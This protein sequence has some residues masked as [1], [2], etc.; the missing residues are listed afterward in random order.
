IGYGVIATPSLVNPIAKTSFGSDKFVKDIADKKVA[1]IN[2]DKNQ[3]NLKNT[4]AKK[5][6]IKDLKT[7]IEE[8]NE[9]DRIDFTGMNLKSYA[10]PEGT[11][12]RNTA[13]SGGR[14]KTAENFVAK[15]FR[16]I[17][18]FKADGFVKPEITVEDWEGFKQAVEES[19]L[20]EKDMVLRVVQ[21]H[22]DP[23]VREQEIRNMTK[24]FET[25]E[26]EIHPKLR[27]SELIVNVM[28]IGNTD[29]EIKELYAN[30]FDKLT[31]EEILYLGTLCENNEKKLEVYTKYTDKYTD[32]W[33]GFN[34]LG[35]VQYEL[36]NIPAAKTALEKAK[37]IDANATV[38][39]NL[40]NVALIEGDVDQAKEYY[41]SATGV[42]EASYGQGIISVQKGQYK[43]AGDYFGADC[44]FNN[45]LA[46]L[47][48]KDYDG[49][50][51]KASCGEDK[52]APMNY[53][54]KAIAN[55]RKD[56]RDETLNNLR[57]AVAKDQALKGRAK[58]DMEFHK[59]F[60]DATFK[61]IVN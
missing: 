32:D 52:D 28:L 40:G 49:A 2:Y 38:F 7:Y 50:I 20:P 4:E 48:A 35:V 36:N 11:V 22:S 37:S 31:Q 53:Y 27:R 30:D 33:R 54:L 23:D 5:D 21:M 17:E 56:N 59:Y 8:A 9:N 13:V 15:E 44:S 39:N 6:E 46:L 47:L 29:E 51:E 34:N 26:Q 24:T 3:Y 10:S 61:E 12:D 14:S 43:E 25:L 41:Q 16:K 19:S 55:A 58:T 18:D 42:N 45:A 1:V 60:E 57:T